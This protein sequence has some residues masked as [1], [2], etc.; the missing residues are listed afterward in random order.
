MSSGGIQKRLER[1]E[2][3]ADTS[4]DAHL[5]ELRKLDH[6]RYLELW[7]KAHESEAGR[8]EYMAAIAKLVPIDPAW[9][10]RFRKE[11][12]AV[13]RERAEVAAHYRDNNPAAA[14][15]HNARPAPSPRA[16]P[17]QQPEAA[18]GW[19]V[20]SDDDEW[21]PLLES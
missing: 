7:M 17:P 6:V 2:Q 9:C 11:L 12:E 4:S 16:Q 10:A 18:G 13:Y 15:V 20:T 21:G 1:L 8:A 5:A 3:A 19:T 14:V